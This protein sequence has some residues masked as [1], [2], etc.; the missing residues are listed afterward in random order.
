MRNQSPERIA[1]EINVFVEN[2]KLPVII[3]KGNSF[4]Q[5]TRVQL[6]GFY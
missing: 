6:R 1:D 3:C 5:M 4:Y 2:R